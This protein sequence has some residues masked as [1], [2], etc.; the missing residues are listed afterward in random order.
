M[1]ELD[2]GGSQLGE[3]VAEPA[4]GARALGGGIEARRLLPASQRLPDARSVEQLAEPV[5]GDDARDLAKPLEVL[6]R[7]DHG[8]GLAFAAAGSQ[9]PGR[10]AAD[11]PLAAQSALSRSTL[12]S[13]V[14]PLTAPCAFESAARSPEKESPRT[15]G[16]ISLEVWC[17]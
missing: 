11:L 15:D 6:D 3:R 10:R 1:A 7:L 13:K 17:A 9:D 8:K 16:V 2:E 5:A 4:R 14:S 12:T